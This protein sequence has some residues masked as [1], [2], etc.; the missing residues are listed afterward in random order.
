MKKFGASLTNTEMAL[1]RKI[2]AAGLASISQIV[3]AFE[4]G[5]DEKIEAWKQALEPKQETAQVE[6][7]AEQTQEAEESASTGEEVEEQEPMTWTETQTG[8]L[9]VETFETKAA[10]VQAS[11]R[12]NVP[13]DAFQNED[14]WHIYSRWNPNMPRNRGGARPGAGRKPD[15]SRFD[16]RSYQAGYQAG[17]R[18]KDWT[19]NA[20][21]YTFWIEN[22]KGERVC[23]NQDDF[24][25]AAEQCEEAGIE[26]TPERAME[27]GWTGFYIGEW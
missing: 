12:L 21:E 10:A 22:Q 20:F 11:F 2:E 5:E 27:E 15:P 13:T 26:L 6:L 14:G 16:A 23:C 1:A 3:K 19:Y 17:H 7:V 24:H 4:R 18:R 8:Y 25:T 9:S